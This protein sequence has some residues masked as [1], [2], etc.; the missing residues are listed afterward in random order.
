[1]DDLQWLN[2]FLDNSIPIWRED[3]VVYFK[4][5]LGFVPDKWQAEAARDLAEAPKVTI[6]S[7]QGV[8]KDGCRSRHLSLVYHL[9]SVSQN[10]CDGSDKTAASRCPVV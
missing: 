5:V 6:K 8:G 7:G 9:F 4:E 1:M 3:P 10:S 2:E